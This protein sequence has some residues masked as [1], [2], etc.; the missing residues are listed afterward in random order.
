MTSVFIQVIKYTSNNRAEFLWG[1]NFIPLSKAT[2][3]HFSVTLFTVVREPCPAPLEIRGMS[4]SSFNWYQIEFWVKPDRFP[5]HCSTLLSKKSNNN[6][7]EMLFSPRKFRRLLLMKYNCPV[8]VCCTACSCG[9]C[10]NFGEEQ[11]KVLL[12]INNPFSK[13]G[14]NTCEGNTIRHSDYMQVSISLLR[15]ALR[16]TSGSVHCSRALIYSPFDP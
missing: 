13:P 9:K 11:S 10:A 14:R 5:M 3:K 15:K 7:R 2:F 12:F 8:K 1:Y 4:A 16:I 6:S